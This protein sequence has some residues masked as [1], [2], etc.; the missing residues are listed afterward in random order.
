T[1]FFQN[2]TSFKVG[3]FTINPYLNE[4]YYDIEFLNKQKAKYEDEYL[5]HIEF[6]DPVVIK[7]DGQKKIGILL[8]P[9]KVEKEE[10]NLLESLLQ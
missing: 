7:I 1:H 8:K 10:L 2:L 9:G 5:R 3:Y 4:G 6:D